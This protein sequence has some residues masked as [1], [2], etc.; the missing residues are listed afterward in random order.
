VGADGFPHVVPIYFIRQGDDVL[1]GTDRGEAKVRN[2]LDNPKAAVV[3]GGDPDE[4][5]EGYMIQGVL[6]VERDPGQATA[7][8]LLLR[9][10]SEGEAES[11]LSEWSEGDT[12][13]LRLK[14]RRVIRVW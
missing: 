6:A 1:F 4:D 7:R 12:V 9:Y 3:I 13:L 5:E 10:E 2:A 14:P 11:Q 8:R